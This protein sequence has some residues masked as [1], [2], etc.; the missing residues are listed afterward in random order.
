MRTTFDHV[1]SGDWETVPCD[2]C[3]ADDYALWA[4][5]RGNTL[6]CCR[7]CGLVWTN[8][9]IR[10][11]AFKDKHLY[12]AGYFQQEDRFAGRQEEA[13]RRMHALERARIE[14]FVP[15]GRILDVGC[16]MGT[17]LAGFGPSWVKHGCDISS[18][19]LE[20]ARQ[21]GIQTLHGEFETLEFPAAPFDVIVMRASLHHT[22]SPRRCLARA[23]DLLRADGLLAICMSNN[24][25]GPMGRLF[26]GHIRSYDQTINYLFSRQ[27]LEE[28]LRRAGYLVLTDEH[29][30]FGT[31]YDSWRDWAS[32]PPR[33]FVYLQARLRGL[34]NGERYRDLSSPPFYGN[35][36]DMYARKAAS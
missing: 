5:A 31:G 27:T 1:Y 17:F 21:R 9:R 33:Y 10:D 7:R 15:R 11:R 16:G 2:L 14:S 34:E 4:R 29:P 36:I 19:G 32:L 26:R 6:V 23:F 13:R 28:Y 22:Y 24:C 18:Y 8:P 30:Y 25:S 12:G 3:G 35:Y 20:E